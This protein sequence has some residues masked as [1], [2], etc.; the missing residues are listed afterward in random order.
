MRLQTGFRNNFSA[1]VV[2]L[3]R[4]NS[5]TVDSF[6]CKYQAICKR[7]PHSTLLQ[8]FYDGKARKVLK[9]SGNQKL[10]FGWKIFGNQIKY[11]RDVIS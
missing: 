10:H 11:D 7:I 9:S 6:D 1:T 4:R 5:L 8:Q 2:S 3:K